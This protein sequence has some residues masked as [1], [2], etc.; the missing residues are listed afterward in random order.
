LTPMDEAAR[1]E[2]E[3]VYL[4]VGADLWRAIYAFSGGRREVANEAVAEAFA[5][6]A[7][8]RTEIRDLRPWLYR[9]AFRL[10]AAEMRHGETPQPP[11]SE[12]ELEP[13]P[14]RSEGYAD[15]IGLLGSLSP[16]QRGAFVLRHV[17][18]YTT[19]ETA[20]LL[21]IGEIAVR[22]HLLAARRRLRSRLQEAERV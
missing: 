21:G 14:S 13:E 4:E 17:Y 1:S 9:T 12:G 2:L 7:G 22:V 16:M 11:H 3:R 5:R 18:L 19:R 10:A 20:K 8:T 15:L 6:A